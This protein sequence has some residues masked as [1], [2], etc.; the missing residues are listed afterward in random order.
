[1]GDD[2]VAW[3]GNC[4]ILEVVGERWAI[5]GQSGPADQGQTTEHDLKLVYLE[6]EEK[7]SVY[8]NALPGGV[9]ISR[10]NPETKLK[11]LA[12]AFIHIDKYGA[13]FRDDNKA[14]AFLKAVEK[15]KKGEVPK[16]KRGKLSIRGSASPRPVRNSASSSGGED[17]AQLLI[18]AQEDRE[19]I[20][21]ELAEIKMSL[22]RIEI[23]LGTSPGQTSGG[24]SQGLRAALTS[25]SMSTSQSAG[26]PAPR[27]PAPATSAP[28][29]PPPP[30]PSTGGPPPPP[31]PSSGPPPSSVAPPPPPAGGPPPPPPPSGGPP[32]PP[33]PSGGPP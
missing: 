30:P 9:L 22:V 19:L 27:A 21:K 33:P 7:W 24:G 17:I 16:K 29:G 8:S 26:P 2:H 28:G 13:K 5:V 11:K 12:R 18:E 6:D 32:P 4:I 23:S 1:M 20:K 3:S 31:P 25:S 15:A 14:E 10:V